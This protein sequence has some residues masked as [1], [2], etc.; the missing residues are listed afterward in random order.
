M[1]NGSR[2]RAKEGGRKEVKGK[3]IN[4]LEIQH[5]RHRKENQTDKGPLL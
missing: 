5:D 4:S 2:E 3:N 1:R